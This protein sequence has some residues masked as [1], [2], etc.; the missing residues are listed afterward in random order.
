M[1]FA[2]TRQKLS[3]AETTKLYKLDSSPLQ[4]SALSKLEHLV[5]QYNQTVSLNCAP[6]L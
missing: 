5:G 2:G 1:V 4:L 6:K 3:F